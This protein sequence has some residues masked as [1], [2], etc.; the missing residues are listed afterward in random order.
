MKTQCKRTIALFLAIAL[1]V[2]LWGCTADADD[3]F[4]ESVMKFVM[5]DLCGMDANEVEYQFDPGAFVL[6]YEDKNA[7]PQYLSVSEINAYE[8]QYADCVSTWYRD[9]LSEEDRTVYNAHLYAMEHCLKGFSLYVSD[10]KKDYTFVRDMLALDSPFLEQNINDDGEYISTW[11]PTAYG[12]RIFFHLEQF[13]KEFWERKMQALE[14]CREIVKNIPAQHKT[15][16]EKMLYLYHYVCDQIT[17]TEYEKL[18]GQEYLYDAVCLGKTVC[19]GYSNMLM[20]LFNLMDVEACEVM[21]GNIQLPDNPTEEELDEY[22]GHTWVAAKLGENYYHFDPTYEDTVD[23]IQEEKTL[24]F[25]VSDEMASSK[26]IDYDTMRPKCMDK[27]RDLSFVH[28]TMETADDQEDITA[29]AELT[30]QRTSDGIY[31]TYIL[32]NEVLDDEKADHMLDEY[33]EQVDHIKSVSI[34]YIQIQENTL[35]LVTT[36]P[37]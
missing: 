25:G 21:G 1:S 17:Y 5:V 27:S 9:K 12:E 11:E 20:L 16:E 24:F 37:W 7:E 36:E 32:V 23:D 30:D 15:Q 13:G 18:S 33:I 34:V 22:E 3:G 10:E 31:E 28:M 2:C 6:F 35:V 8:S 29:L 26:Y 4:V 14:Q 19:D